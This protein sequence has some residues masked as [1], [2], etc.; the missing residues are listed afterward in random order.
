MLFDIVFWKGKTHSYLWRGFNSSCWRAALKHSGQLPLT[1]RT[2]VWETISRLNA[3]GM[4]RLNFSNHV[5]VWTT[6]CREIGVFNAI[7]VTIVWNFHADVLLITHDSLCTTW[8]K[9]RH[10]VVLRIV[11][12]I[13]DAINFILTTCKTC[14]IVLFQ[15]VV[16]N[17]GCHELH[18]RHCLQLKRPA[19]LAC[20]TLTLQRTFKPERTTRISLNFRLKSVVISALQIKWTSLTAQRL[21]L[22]IVHVKRSCSC[23]A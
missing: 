12:A 23:G 3:A 5:H 16:C 10:V 1:R 11:S 18:T 14:A 22:L 17:A 2:I 9:S 21:S 13:Y 20:S 4:R 8:R 6:G 19:P 7:R 15:V